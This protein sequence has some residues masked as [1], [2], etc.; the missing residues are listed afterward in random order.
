M[1]KNRRT[2]IKVHWSESPQVSHNKEVTPSGLCVQKSIHI[3]VHARIIGQIGGIMRMDPQF[4]RRSMGG[5]GPQ[6][7]PMR[8]PARTQSKTKRRWL[9]AP[10]LPHPQN[11]SLPEP[12][13]CVGLPVTR[14]VKT[15]AS[16]QVAQIRSNEAWHTIMCMIA[17]SRGPSP[18]IQL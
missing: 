17:R 6:H 5:W 3:C 12:T 9:P 11:Y 16:A 7:A 15:A 2:V 4:A 14:H 18:I 1:I 13:T 8:P 10:V